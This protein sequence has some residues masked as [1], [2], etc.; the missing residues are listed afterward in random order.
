MIFPTIVSG[1]ATIDEGVG[2][3]LAIPKPARDW[4]A[5]G[6]L[7]RI[8]PAIENIPISGNTVVP[9]P[10]QILYRQPDAVFVYAT[11]VGIL[12]EVGLSGLVEIMVEPKHPIESRESIWRRM[13]EIAGKKTRVATLLDG[14]AAE[15]T[16]MEKE[17]APHVT[18]KL[19]VAY[20][21]VN[22]GDWFTTNGNY[23]VAYKLE[24]AVAQNVSKDFKFTAKADLEQLL[25]LDPDTIVFASSP[26]DKTTLREIVGKPELQSLRAVREHRV[27][28][29][30]LH[31]YMNEPVEDRLLLTWMAEVFYPDVMP[32]RLRDEY[33]QTYQEVY[34]YAISD[35]EIDK[36]IY[37]EEN[38][39]SAGYDRF[40]RKE[41]G[42]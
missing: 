5:D 38:R 27:Y 39:S 12:K 37:L 13:G 17:L 4:A 28:K 6:L 22:R 19:R 32:R 36:A 29:L 2:H 41:S 3:I 34:H 9:D 10:E 7:N 30:P 33:R 42:S 31:T 1:Y 20:V 21:H 26:G 11:Q 14:W 35:D 23:Y 18:R 8:Y 24:L 15:R 40:A 25:L 16:A